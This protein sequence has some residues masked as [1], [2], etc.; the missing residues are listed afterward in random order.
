MEKA[1]DY[2]NFKEEE[3]KKRDAF[4]IKAKEYVQLKEFELSAVQTQF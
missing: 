2:V 3:I 1:K 4:I